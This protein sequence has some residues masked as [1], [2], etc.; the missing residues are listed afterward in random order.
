MLHSILLSIVA[1]VISD[2]TVLIIN[3]VNRNRAF[4]YRYTIA[5]LLS[6]WQCSIKMVKRPTFAFKLG[7]THEIKKHPL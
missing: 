2:S 6:Q 1:R 3:L 4:G 7:V 5:Q